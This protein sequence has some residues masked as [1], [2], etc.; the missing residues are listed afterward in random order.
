MW[1]NG[2]VL[3]KVQSTHLLALQLTEYVEIYLF[4]TFWGLRLSMTWWAASGKSLSTYG[5][6]N[7]RVPPGKRLPSAAGSDLEPCSGNVREEIIQL[8]STHRFGAWSDRPVTTTTCFA[9]I[10]TGTSKTD[11]WRQT[12]KLEELAK[13]IRSSPG[14]SHG[15]MFQPVPCNLNPEFVRWSC[16]TGVPE[17]DD[18]LITKPPTVKRVVATGKLCFCLPTE[19]IVYC[20]IALIK[21]EVFHFTSLFFSPSKVAIM[22]AGKNLEPLAVPVIMKAWKCH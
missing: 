9:D 6:L 1:T 4:T 10:L 2:S 15:Q 8:K 5:I 7:P 12:R 3:F 21:P 16:H 14:K 22:H 11:L 17:P 18:E 13:S 19:I 20:D